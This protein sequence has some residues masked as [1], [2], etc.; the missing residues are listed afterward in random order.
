[1][2]GIA[3]YFNFKP[4]KSLAW[5]KKDITVLLA[6]TLKKIHYRGVSQNESYIEDH[7]GM[8]T[9]RL[10]IVD[11]KNGRQPFQSKNKEI[12]CVLNGEIYNYLEIK[13]KLKKIGY[14]FQ[15][16]CDSEVIVN[17][18]IHW[19]KSAFSQFDGMFAIILYDKK[20][21]SFIAAR[22]PHG[23]K[24]LYYITSPKPDNTILFASEIIALDPLNNEVKE[25]SA[26]HLFI[27]GKN[28]YT[29]SSENINSQK[30]HKPQITA[31]NLK[32]LISNAVK[33]RVQTELPIAVF[34]SGGIDSS[35][36]LYE[37]MQHHNKVEAFVIGN[38]SAS[39]VIAAKFLCAELG[40]PLTHIKAT[41]KQLLDLI[42]TTIKTIESFE[43]NHIR[44]GTLSYLLSKAVSKKG[45]K[46]AL[47]GEGADEL[48]CGYGEFIRAKMTGESNDEIKATSQ[49]FIKQLY[50]T[51][52]QRVDRTSMRHTLEVRVPFLDIS[53]SDFA[54]HIPIEK[55]L[56]KNKNN[57]WQTKELLRQAYQNIL[58]N[59][60]VNREKSV[61]SAG[62]GFGSNGAEG[63]FYHH[64]N[65]QISHE[66]LILYQTD[67]PEFALQNKEEVLYFSFYKQ[68]FGSQFFA[69]QRP[70]VNKTRVDLT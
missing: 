4:D 6:E 33:K 21:N 12:S 31:T 67:F 2:C 16:N 59:N 38:D 34:L 36:I 3:A 37:A 7:W 1:M 51:Q 23:I 57:L 46:V 22:D 64:A 18:Y 54:N 15:S 70:L 24:P 69:T 11:E 41:D 49:L 39:D 55:L 50:K 47:C 43:P 58:P 42:P 40:T 62:A 20:N 10:Q 65:Q 35:I 30:L 17:A 56:R 60:I 61:L 25:V 14:I 8:G 63:I 52:L 45:Y 44:G 26:G 19:G 29:Y 5:K 32:K 48:F 28:F 68:Y 9:N 66:K 27:D 13:Q 53:V